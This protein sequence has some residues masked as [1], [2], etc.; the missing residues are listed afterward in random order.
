MKME[1]E[2]IVSWVER[3]VNRGAFLQ[4]VTIPE[5]EFS[6]CHMVPTSKH[7]DMDITEDDWEPPLPCFTILT[8]DLSAFQN[9]SSSSP[10]SSKNEARFTSDMTN[11][12]GWDSTDWRRP[13]R[14]FA[15]PRKCSEVQ[16][17]KVL[18]KVRFKTGNN[19]GRLQ[20]G[21]SGWA[22]VS[23]TNPGTNMM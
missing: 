17:D 10:C 2:S 5:R 20:A 6:S 9:Q 18:R 4:H 15:H 19:E 7:E 21:F 16:W 1:G 13:D 14:D 12:A 3:E 23:G 11:Q 22:I 8:D